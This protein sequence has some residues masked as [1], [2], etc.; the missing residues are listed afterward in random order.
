M[1][2][3]LETNIHPTQIRRVR[4]HECYRRCSIE[5]QFRYSGDTRSGEDLYVGVEC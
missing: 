4:K 3:P 2:N 1:E 5:V